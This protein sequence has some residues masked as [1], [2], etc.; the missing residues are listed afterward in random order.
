M[1]KKRLSRNAALII[2]RF[3]KQNIREADWWDM[4]LGFCVHGDGGV[5]RCWNGSPMGDLYAEP[6]AFE[7]SSPIRAVN[8]LLRGE[9]PC[10]RKKKA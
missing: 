10:K 4:G 6:V 5:F 3:N 8:W 2:L 1:R 9:I 7:T